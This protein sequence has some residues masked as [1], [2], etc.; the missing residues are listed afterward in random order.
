MDHHAATLEAT[1]LPEPTLLTDILPL[2][3]DALLLASVVVS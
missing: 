3:T 1:A 2:D